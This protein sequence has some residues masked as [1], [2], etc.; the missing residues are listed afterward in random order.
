MLIQELD[1]IENFGNMK[2]VYVVSDAVYKNVATHVMTHDL[3]VAT[4]SAVILAFN[5]YNSFFID[6]EFP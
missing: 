4:N 1:M 2:V 6:K 3:H 5:N